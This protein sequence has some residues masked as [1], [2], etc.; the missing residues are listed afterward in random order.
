MKK[1]DRTP[2]RWRTSWHLH[3]RLV[4]PRQCLFAADRSVDSYVVYE[5]SRRKEWCGIGVCLLTPTNILNQIDNLVASRTASMFAVDA[6]P[7]M[8]H[9]LINFRFVVV[10]DVAVAVDLMVVATEFQRTFRHVLAER[11]VDF[12]VG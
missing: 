2:S 9:L 10:D 8:I 4:G 1:M 11:F 5:L 3:S 12:G 6:A 7:M